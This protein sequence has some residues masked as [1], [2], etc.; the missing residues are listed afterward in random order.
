[1][2]T[3][4][5]G[6]EL[7]VV[8]LYGGMRHKPQP[9]WLDLAD[10]AG[11]QYG[12]VS[13]R[14][15]R[16]LGFSQDTIKREAAVGRLHP[17]HH[18]VYAVGHT[19][20]S[21][22]SECLAAGLG[23]GPG[24]LLSH[25][26]A[27]WLWGLSK[28]SPVPVHVTGPVARRHRSS[29]RQHRSRTLTDDDRA[30]ERGIPVTSVARTALDLAPLLRFDRMKRLLKRS[31][32]LKAFDLPAFES[33]LARNKGH[34]GR[35]PLRRALA[36]YEPP[37]FTRSGL[38]EYFLHLVEQ[39]GLP[40]PVPAYNVAGH[41][42]DVYW[43]EH[44]FAVELDV[45]ETH[46]TRE[47]FEEDRLRDEDLGLAGIEVRRVTGHRLEREPQRVIERITRMLAERTRTPS[48]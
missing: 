42:L 11:R 26:S 31:E 21:A 29:I 3:P 14:Q 40:Q 45:F 36:T 2:P 41:E 8:E 15:L 16:R 34:R 28:A 39:A 46:G 7:Q 35:R 20:L 6:G 43:P 9:P 27:A 13:I 24:A 32:E 38:E 33:V 25:Y 44:R 37:R 12:V 47:S 10:L 23:G 17:L 48:R 18:G 19:D 4:R 30:L 22:Y 1:M 5:P